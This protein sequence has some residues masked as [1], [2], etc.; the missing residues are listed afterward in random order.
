MCR[1][2]AAGFPD[3]LV[4]FCVC[5]LA[6]QVSERAL[7]AMMG[8][9][10][11]S[12]KDKR[13]PKSLMQPE[14]MKGDKS[15]MSEVQLKELK[16]WDVK[17][18]RWLEETEKEQAA[19]AA[20]LKKLKTD[21]ADVRSKFHVA[22]V[23]LQRERLTAQVSAPLSLNTAPPNSLL[24]TTPREHSNCAENDLESHLRWLFPKRMG[25]FCIGP[26]PLLQLVGLRSIHSLA[27]HN[28][29]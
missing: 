18:K 21:A 22:F 7:K 29:L 27:W 15:A 14:W 13:G 24:F 26:M 20:E 28:S 11:A 9:K 1:K 19:L 12:D 23:S 10:L 8:G 25:G 5:L 4:L 3:G 6:E 17:V 2:E 16:E